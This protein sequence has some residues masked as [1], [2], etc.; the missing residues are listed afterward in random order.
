[1]CDCVINMYRA[2]FLIELYP[3]DMSQYYNILDQWRE[4]EMFGINLKG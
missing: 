4:H 2:L 3:R 1:M